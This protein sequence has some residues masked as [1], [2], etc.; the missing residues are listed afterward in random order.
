[1]T[2]PQDQG[3]QLEL[4]FGTDWN[5]HPGVTRRSLDLLTEH[6]VAAAFGL[7]VSTLEKW[8]AAGFG[9]AYTKPGKRVFY[10]V[11]DVRAWLATRRYKPSGSGDVAGVPDD[12]EP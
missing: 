5:Q 8:R 6:E 2:E 9:P 4:D 10:S 7:A 11:Y 3:E 12:E 1:M